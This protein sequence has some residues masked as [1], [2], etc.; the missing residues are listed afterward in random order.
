MGFCPG[1]GKEIG[2]EEFCPDCRPKRSRKAQKPVVFCTCGKVLVKNVWRKP[3]VAERL[4]KVRFPAGLRLKPGIKETVDGF[5]YEV[6][7][8]PACS[9]AGTRYFEATLQLRNPSDEAI[10]RVNSEVGKAEGV[11]ATDFKEVRGG[12]DVKLTRSGFA[13]K[14]ARKLVSEFGGTMSVSDHLYSR[15]HQTSKALKRISVKVRLPG[16]SPGDVIAC[17]GKAIRITSLGETFSGVDLATGKRWSK[18]APEWARLEVKEAQLTRLKPHPEVMDPETFQ[19]ER[20]G[21]KVSGQVGDTISVVFYHGWL[22][23]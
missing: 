13:V 7:T 5:S 4:L 18:K 22:A 19:S 3:G 11:H 14:L 2:K 20:L 21:G 12:V 16:L 1:C 6:R 17:D 8:C 23:V 15:D 10:D 9:K